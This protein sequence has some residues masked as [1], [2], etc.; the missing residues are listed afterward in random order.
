MIAIAGATG[1]VGGKISEILIDEGH[2]VL[3]VA[4]HADGLIPM[5]DRGAA[6]AAISLAQTDLL[7]EAFYGA[8]S[9][10]AMIPPNYE[11]PDF[12][13]YQDM[14]G[15]SLCEAIAQAG[16]THVVNLSSVGAD[17]PHGT[18]PIRGLHAQEQRLNAL[19]G[20]HVLHLRPA[21]F[22]ENLL[23][24]VDLIRTQNI[25]GSPL[26][27]DLRIPMIATRDIAA[28]AARY[29]SER[30]FTGKSVVEL[31]GPRDL[32]MA[33]AAAIIGRKLD[34]PDLNYVQFT[35]E[36]T[37]KALI[38]MGFSADTAGLFIE[39]ER[40]FNA[41]LIRTVRTGKNTTDTPLEEFAHIFR[42]LVPAP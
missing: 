5:T 39:M 37:E 28:A 1:N 11:A 7:A 23:M 33:E 27:P 30:N 15:E 19:S 34:R 25:M 16:V 3:C 2:K 26:R 21:Y 42:S 35:Y 18:G 9:V 22:M 41:G 32:S 10:F 6:A 12:S 29:L 14:I 31:L 40:A 38:E 13:A 36:D 20:V 8:R 17:L 4:R 24:N